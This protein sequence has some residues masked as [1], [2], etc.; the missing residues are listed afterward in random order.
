MSGAAFPYSGTLAID[1]GEPVRGCARPAIPAHF[2]GPSAPDAAGCAD[3]DATIQAI[4]T[5]GPA[6]RFHERLAFPAT[7]RNGDG[8][9][10]AL[11]NLARGQRNR[12][13]KGTAGE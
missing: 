4:E 1:G 12:P 8:N 11:D 3:A 9:S 10:V 7:V 5:D 2:H 6:M 13:G